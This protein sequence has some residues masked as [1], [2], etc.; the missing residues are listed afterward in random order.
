MEKSS[1]ESEHVETR[2]ELPSA[3]EGPAAIDIIGC[4][5]HQEA[6]ELSLHMLEDLLHSSDL[7]FRILSTRTL[8]S[9]VLEHVDRDRPEAVVIA[10]LPPGGLIQAR[11]L[12]NMIHKRFPD[13]PIVVGCWTY[14][15]NL[16]RVIVKLR[17][18]GAASVTTT[19][20]GAKEH[21]LSFIRRPEGKSSNRESAAAP[22]AVK[23]SKDGPR[24]VCEN[25]PNGHHGARL[26]SAGKSPTTRTIKPK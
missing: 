26:Y 14:R 13:L 6:E 5:S 4:A 7:H 24:E 8:P 17:S 23:R 25:A 1:L 16:D 2:E 21:V 20:Q 22:P 9:E 11:Y 15:G 12:C 10:A 19:L 18:A 3:N